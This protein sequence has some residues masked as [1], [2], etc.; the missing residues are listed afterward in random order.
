MIYQYRYQCQYDDISLRRTMWTLFLS[1]SSSSSWSKI[2]RKDGFTLAL[3]WAVGEGKY[4]TVGLIISAWTCS[5]RCI[6]CTLRH[7]KSHNIHRV[8]PEKVRPSTWVCQILADFHNSF[9][10]ALVMK[11]AIKQSLNIP[12]H[13]KRVAT[14][15]C[16]IRVLIAENLLISEIYHIISLHKVEI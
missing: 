7:A 3:S 13:L 15:P 8:G 16:E 12:H 11:F 4:I 1:P 14:L 9:T 2:Q 10:I 6:L 5:S